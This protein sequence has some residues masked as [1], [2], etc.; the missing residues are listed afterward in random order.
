MGRYGSFVGAVLGGIG[1]ALLLFGFGIWQPSTTP[2]A[3]AI[4][5]GALSLLGGYYAYRRLK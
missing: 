5:V 1:V 2:N 4:G 3:E